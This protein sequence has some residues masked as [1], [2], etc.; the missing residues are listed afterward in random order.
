MVHPGAPTL[1]AWLSMHT[2]AADVRNQL[3]ELKRPGGGGDQ[4][5]DEPFLRG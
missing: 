2:T 1:M 3:I 5:G 4:S